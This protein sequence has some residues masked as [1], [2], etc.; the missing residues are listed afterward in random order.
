MIIQLRVNSD[1]W[2]ANCIAIAS[3]WITLHILTYYHGY[4]GAYI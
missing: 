2:H 3:S 1:V 4:T